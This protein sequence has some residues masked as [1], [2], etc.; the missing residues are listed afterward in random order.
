M[1]LLLN[2]TY[3]GTDSLNDLSSYIIP[4]PSNYI[5]R[6]NS[7]EENLY[8]TWDPKEDLGDEIK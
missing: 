3:F 7:L 6:L 2:P 8:A 5:E 4:L 1:A